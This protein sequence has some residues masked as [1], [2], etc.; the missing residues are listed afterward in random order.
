MSMIQIESIEKNL[1]ASPKT[2]LITGAAGFIGSNLLERLLRLGQTVVGLDNFF[3]G[4]R[5]NLA[6]V[7][8]L[9]ARA[10]WRR[11]TFI[12]GDIRDHAVCTKACRGVDFVLHQAAIGSVPRSMENPQRTNEVNVS[13]TLNMLLAARDERVRRFVFASSSSVYGDCARLP[14]SEETVGR[15]LSPYAVS[16]YADELYARVFSS[17]FGLDTIG[18]RYFNVFGPR[19]DPNG[20]YAAVIPKW[21]SAMIHDEPCYINGTGETSRDFCYVENVVQANLLAA[22]TLNPQALN[23]VYNVALNAQISLNE[24]YGNIYSKLSAHYPHLMNYRPIHRDFR[25]GDIMHSRAAIDKARD[26][27]G[28]SPTH[29]VAAGLGASLE[30]YMAN[31]S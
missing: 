29:T 11:F 23:Q 14:Q 18:L 6:E 15:P 27:L 7:Q 17:A 30:W 26:L 8:S 24:L 21:I 4:K 13:G 31:L 5:E 25:P 9:V 2:W 16:K 10:Q 19:Q 1:E 28:Y 22:T 3:A 12:E 20:D